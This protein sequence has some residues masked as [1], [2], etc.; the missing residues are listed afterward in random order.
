[1][2]GGVEPEEVPGTETKK[3]VAVPR[4]CAGEEGLEEKR[5]QSHDR[6]K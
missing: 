5:V 2:E 3:P 1:M 4:S 6:L